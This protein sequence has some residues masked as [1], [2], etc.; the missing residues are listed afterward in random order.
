MYQEWEHFQWDE[1][2]PKITITALSNFTVL[3]SFT[4]KHV[5][6]N[7]GFSSNFPA[8]A[9]DDGPIEHS[10]L[11]I[12]CKIIWEFQNVILMFRDIVV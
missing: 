4:W 12:C 6:E 11:W 10:S 8:V 1:L 9:I 2:A 7:L 5:S 3:F